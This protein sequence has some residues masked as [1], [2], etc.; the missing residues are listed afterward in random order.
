MSLELENIEKR[1]TIPLTKGEWLAFF[2]VPVNPNWRLNP[3]SANQI[4]FERYKKFGFEKKIEQAEK[5]RIAGILFYLL[6]IL[7]AIIISSF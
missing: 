1:K 6:I 4:E 2:F 5:A 7:V 3:K